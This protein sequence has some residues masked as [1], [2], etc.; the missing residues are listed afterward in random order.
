MDV[1]EHGARGVGVVGDVHLATGKFPDQPAVDGAE[2]QFTLART[3]TAAFDV[4]E[5]PLE[6]GA[7][8][9]RVGNQAGGVA[10][11]LLVTIA[12]ELLADFGAAAALPD[13][14]VVDRAAGGLVPDHGGFA[15]VGDAD[16]RDLVV[17]QAGLRQGLDHHGA[18]G[19][20]DFHRVMLDPT[21][22][23]VMLCE[24]ALGGADHVRVTV[25]K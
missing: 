6:L 1:E 20:E 10:D 21:G 18:L 9:V 22:L 24:F 13:D 16:G 8:E 19:G 4:V 23:R 2:Q 25:E 12:L 3:L 11:V 5:D 17:M 7:G 14:R 15:L